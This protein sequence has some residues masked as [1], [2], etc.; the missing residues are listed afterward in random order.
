MIDGKYYIDT[1]GEKTL[2]EVYAFTRHTCF[3]LVWTS[4][5]I[6]TSQYYIQQQTK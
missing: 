1:N 6:A 4:G 3:H 5:F 2:S